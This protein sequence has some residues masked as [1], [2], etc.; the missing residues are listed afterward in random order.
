MQL[1]EATL[2]MT[3]MAFDDGRAAEADRKLMVVFSQRA[4]HDKVESAK[5]G[6][7]IYKDR[8]YI[9]IMVPGDKDTVIERPARD[10]DI[11]RFSRQYD[12]YKRKVSQQAA[13]GTPL[14]LVPFLNESQVKELEYFN[15]HTVEQL[16]DLTDG[17]AQGFMGIQVLKQK[18]AAYLKAASEL[19]PL[20]AMKAE[21]EKKD[22][23]L[24]A[25]AQAIKEMGDR[26][27]ALE[28]KK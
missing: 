18:A 13:A 27:K 3:S 21:I 5:Q 26:L 23:E 25:Q 8:D 16:A 12:A 7:P 24:A 9:T 2:E 15:C 17:N 19:A 1:Q 10:T 14:R 11:E 28:A 20:T 4:W 6:R 22:A